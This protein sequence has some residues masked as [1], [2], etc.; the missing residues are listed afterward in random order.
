MNLYKN[1]LVL[2][3]AIFSY[4]TGCKE[5]A[6]IKKFNVL[7]ITIDDLRP[8]LGCY[9][10]SIV[11]S[12]NIDH[13][14]SQGLVFKRAYC[15][16]AICGPSRTSFLTG[17]RP[18]TIG[19]NDLNTHIRDAAPDV[20]TLPQLFKNSGYYTLGLFKVFHLVGFDPKGFGNMNDSLSWSV[21]L[22]MPSRSAWGPYGD[23]IFQVNYQECLKNGPIGYNN[24]PRSLAFEAPNIADSLISDGETTQQAIRYLHQ[25]KDKPFF[26]AVGFY[27]PHLPYVAPQKYWDLYKKNELKLPDNQYPPVGAP[28]YAPAGLGGDR[29]LR[30]YTNIPDEGEL[31][32][33]LKQNLLHGYLAS[34]SYVDAQVG[35]LINELKSLGLDKNTIIVLLGDHGYQ[36]GEHNMWGKKHTNYE[37]ST[38]SPLIISVPGKVKG[39]TTN[40]LTEFID[41]YPTLTELCN[42]KAPKNLDGISLAPLMENPHQNIKE[43]AF[44]MYPRGTRVGT[45]MRNDQYRFIVWESLIE[46]VTEYELYDHLKDTDEN[47]NLA[48]DPLYSAVMNEL[49]EKFNT[50]RP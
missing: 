33:E 41:L 1:I 8:Q 23:S 20:I 5:K 16:Q 21:P 38:H 48:N 4:C 15:Q 32:E 47:K 19:I 7:F 17:L 10:D 44:S 26:M 13:L 11:K 27:K 37:I 45:S 9:G 28:D 36:I 18:E 12:P 34:I 40:S 49:I 39:A 42:L 2:V 6:Q 46:D 31:N 35:L 25:L 43:A 30:S 3:L 24:I 22:W 14:A 29:E 50:L